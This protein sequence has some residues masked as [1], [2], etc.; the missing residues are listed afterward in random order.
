MHH[1]SFIKEL[2]ECT[3]IDQVNS[4]LDDSED[5]WVL[6]N[7]YIADNKIRMVVGRQEVPE[8]IQ[9]IWDH[10]DQTMPV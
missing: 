1:N 7:H 6:M 2:K 4:L 10:Q 3:S 5:D 8:K 9:E